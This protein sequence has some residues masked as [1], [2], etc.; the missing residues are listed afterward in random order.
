MKLN[1]RLLTMFMG[2]FLALAIVF[3]QLFHFQLSNHSK[4]KAKT[5]QNEEKQK[6]SDETSYNVLP[7]FSI[8]AQATIELDV[9][10]FCLFEI[11]F[12]EESEEKSSLESPHYTSKF[13]LNLFRVIISPNAP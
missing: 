5:E 2:A 10:S 11:S 13:L 9:E 4:A 1:V 3:S 6:T 7:S 12:E 8:P